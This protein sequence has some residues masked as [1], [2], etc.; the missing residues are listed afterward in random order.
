M[1]F[2]EENNPHEKRSKINYKTRKQKM[3]PHIIFNPKAAKK[4]RKQTHINLIKNSTFYFHFVFLREGGFKRS[5]RGV[6]FYTRI[7]MLTIRF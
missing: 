3:K 1:C 7:L 2:S 4:Q 5:C 6:K